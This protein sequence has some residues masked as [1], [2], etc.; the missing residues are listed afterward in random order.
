[1]EALAIIA[2]VELIGLTCLQL[3]LAL[4]LPLGRVAWGGRQ[5]ILPVGLRIASFFSTG[6]LVL[7]SLIILERVDLLTTLNHEGVVRYGTWIMS[8]FFAMNTLGNITLKSKWE[9]MIATPVSTS[10]CVFCFIIAVIA[11]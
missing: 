9:R 11:D 1:M 8:S 5:R 2:A 6:I 10:L 3:L 7:L 4:G